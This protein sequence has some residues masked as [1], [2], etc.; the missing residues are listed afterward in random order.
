M[1]TTMTLGLGAAAAIGVGLGCAA[2]IGLQPAD[3]Q[4]ACINPMDQAL[5]GQH[6]ATFVGDLVGCSILNATDQTAASAC[7]QMKTGISPQCADCAAASGTCSTQNCASPCMNGADTMACQTCVAMHCNPGLIACGGMPVYACVD[8]ADMAAVAKHESTIPADI[9]MCGSMHEGQP[10]AVIG[11]L[12]QTDELSQPCATCWAEQG[13]CAITQCTDCVTSPMAASC[14]GCVA[15][16]CAPVF[17]L[18]SGIPLDG[19]IPPDSG[20]G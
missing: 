14:M 10:S 19:G 18:C 11:C 5:L 6:Q 4:P 7:I 2:I 9:K 13:L 15:M 16:S 1:K 3:P 12:Q 20:P 17:A 8:M